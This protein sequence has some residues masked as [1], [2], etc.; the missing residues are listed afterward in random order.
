[1]APDP[2]R[3]RSKPGSPNH[4]DGRPSGS[5]VAAND[6]GWAATPSQA[7]TAERAP[8]ADSNE[9]IRTRPSVEPSSSWPAR[10]GCGISPT[11]L[12]PALQMPAM[13]STEPLGLST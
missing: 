5:A 7:D 13:S 10:S 9:L 12:R 4:D 11:T 1:P 6:R 8:A 2:D 3:P